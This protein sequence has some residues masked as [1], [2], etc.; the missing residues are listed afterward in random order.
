MCIKRHSRS[1]HE[2]K[3]KGNAKKNHRQNHTNGISLSPYVKI[4]LNNK[5]SHAFSPPPTKKGKQATQ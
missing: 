1:C 5:R 2:A 4:F 3:N